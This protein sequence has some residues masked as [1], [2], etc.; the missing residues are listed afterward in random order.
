MPQS[1]EEGGVRQFIL[2]QV[3]HSIR[4]A[5]CGAR[6]SGPDISVVEQLENV[7][8]LGAVCPNCDSQAIVMVVVQRQ[9]VPED[10]LP[11]ISSDDVLDFHNSLGD[12]GGDL[13]Q[14]LDDDR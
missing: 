4:C 6:Y 8:I 5:A 7:W 1:P 10:R 14:L 2:R 12:F 9:P 13:R 11:A 3:L